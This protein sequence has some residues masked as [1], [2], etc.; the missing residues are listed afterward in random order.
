MLFLYLIAQ[1]QK[2]CAKG[3]P[4]AHYCIKKWGTKSSF[5]VTWKLS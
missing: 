5:L 2:K 4:F 1:K 3:I